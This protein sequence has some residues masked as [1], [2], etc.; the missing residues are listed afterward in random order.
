MHR[1]KTVVCYGCLGFC[2]ALLLCALLGPV[3]TY[4]QDQPR[5]AP[6]SDEQPQTPPKEEGDTPAPGPDPD[7]VPDPDPDPDLEDQVDPI[8][9]RKELDSA[10]RLAEQVDELLTDEGR[11][12]PDAGQEGLA[13]L[14]SLVTRCE[15]MG[16]STVN[17]RPRALLL[18]T[19]AR[20]LAALSRIEE[21][22]GKADNAIAPQRIDQLRQTAQQIGALDL[23][24]AEPTSGY[25]QLLSELDTN[26]RSRASITSRQALAEQQLRGYIRQHK[27]DPMANEFVVDARLSLARLLDQ[28]GD[29]FG[30][31]KQL[32]AIGVLDEES[33]RAVEVQQLTARTQLIGQAIEL[34][35]V[36]TQ[37]QLWRL[38]DQK[39]SPLLVHVYA[40]AVEP[41]VAMIQQ[42][43]RII[44]T[45]ALGG[46]RLVS[47]RVGEPVQGTVVPPW[48][49]LPLDPKPGGVL[50]Q[51]GVDRL[52]TLIWVDPQ[53]RLASIGHTLAVLDQMP[54][55]KP[56][57]GP[58]PASKPQ[59]DHPDAG[60]GQDTR[61]N[62]VPPE[63]EPESG[64]VEGSVEPE[65]EI[66]D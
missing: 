29:Q 65:S 44:A 38:S 22:R 19:Q 23:P 55:P 60:G 41:S 8:S 16:N 20:A 33:P 34:E 11:L 12:S 43:Q 28:R 53:G 46:F 40:D 35:A 13:R 36:T 63:V 32:K 27:D 61:E 42:V 14:K 37:L 10:R 59:A 52:P 48:P 6:S 54:K 3:A 64:A 5:D 31:G 57:P 21:P 62:E 66:V 58:E 30:A 4:A 47:I 56:E 7:A 18:A 50:E 39:G 17:D 1:F 45:R 9:L 2:T 49:T 25:W 51:M 24:A 15:V 26:A